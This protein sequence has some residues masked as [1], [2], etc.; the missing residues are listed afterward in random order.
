M[1]ANDEYSDATK[2]MAEALGIEESQVMSTNNALNDHLIAQKEQ[3]EETKRLVNMYA[4]YTDGILFAEAVQRDMQ[5]NLHELDRET[6]NYSKT[7]EEST[8]VVNENA[9]SEEKAAK[10]K[11]DIALP[12]LNRVIDAMENLNDMRSKRIY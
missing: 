11:R 7:V 12:T 2:A 3:R 9:G 8:E 6:A 10:A 4:E 5:N 1:G